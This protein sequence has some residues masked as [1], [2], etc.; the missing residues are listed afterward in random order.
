MNLTGVEALAGNVPLLPA[1]ASTPVLYKYND[2]NTTCY[3]LKPLLQQRCATLCLDKTVGSS[4]KPM[5]VLKFKE[6]ST[7]KVS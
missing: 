7:V 1:K 4:S 2:T 6:L 5:E 3:R